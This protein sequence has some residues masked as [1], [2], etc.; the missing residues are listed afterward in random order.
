MEVVTMDTDS[1]ADVDRGASWREL[2]STMIHNVEVTNASVHNFAAR[3]SVRR[4]NGISCG[5]FWSRP[6]ELRGGREQLSDAGTAG[7]LV[8]WQIEGEA[9]INQGNTRLL[10][11]P[12]SVAI[13]DGRRPMHISFP[14]DVRRIVAKLPAR[15][16]EDRLPHLLTSH[17]VSF[18]PQGP[19]SPI[20]FAH[21]SEL[22]RE[23]SLFA[24]S[25]VELLVENIANLLRIT[26]GQG[27]A[28]AYSPKELRR[29]AVVRYVQQEACNA[30]LSLEA[31]AGHLNM[32][33]R[34]IQQVLQEMETNFTALLTEARLQ[35]A[36][37]KLSQA[38]ELAVSRAAFGSGF[39][40][41]SHFNHLFKRRFG[42]SP[43]DYRK[44]SESSN[45]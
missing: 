10:Q 39:N 42:M 19:F 4:H 36:A 1:V 40:D 30:D 38:P 17:L 9:Q 34:L 21:F 15:V 45:A 26:S 22:S 12:G 14:H 35:S 43:S 13:V 2:V 29:Q 28:T 24:A 11:T 8:S 33:R 25:D 7:Y 27:D 3:I 20:L 44:L 18:H 5:S 6:H 41:V 23:N 37:K 16:I 32:S 31:V